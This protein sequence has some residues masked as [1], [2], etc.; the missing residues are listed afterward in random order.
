MR[1]PAP[2]ELPIFR[3]TLQAR[4]L[5]LLLSDP[6]RRWTARELETRLDAVQQTL[7][8]ELRRLVGAGLLHADAVGRTKLYRAAVESPL[9]EPLRE[10]V[11]RT[12][13]AEAMLA[14][15]LGGLAGVEA[16][17]IFGS[18]ASGEPLRPSSD[19][20]VL[21][22]GDVDFDRV[23][24]AVRPVEEVAGRDVH[25]VAYRLDELRARAG[26][27]GFARSVLQGPLRML[28]GDEAELRAV[29]A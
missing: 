15:A 3:S 14:R 13:G 6:E 29:A 19:V 24:D 26:A 23:A 9:F 7:N 17:A 20:D 28:V 22:V 10:L 25:L 16:A 21:V 27:D 12:V 1:V 8:N 2:R 5:A 11:A 4:L 18:A